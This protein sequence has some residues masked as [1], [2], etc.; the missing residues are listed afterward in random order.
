MRIGIVVNPDAGL[1]GKLGFK[2]SDGR[3]AEARAAG[4]EDRAGPR[5]QQCLTHL[6]SLTA[7]SL[8][9][10]QTSLTFVAWEGR[11]GS[12]WIPQVD[13]SVAVGTEWVGSTPDSTSAEDTSSLVNALLDAE[14]DALLYAGG[15]GTTRDIVKALENRGEAAQE[16]P[17]I[18]VPGGVK[19][20]SGCFATTPKAAAEVVLSFALGDLRTAITE[21]MDLDEVVYQ[22]GVWKVR[23]YGE[24]W[25][26]SSPRF[27]QGAKEQVERVSEDDSIEGLANHIGSLLEDED[28]LMVVWGSGGTL[29]RMGEHLNQSLTLLGIDI[30]HGGSLHNDLD[31]SELIR[32]LGEHVDEDGQQR[33]LLLLLS[34]M[35]GQGFLIGRGNLQLSPTVLRLVG[36]TN[37]LGVATPSKLI[38]LE[39][40]R[41]DTGDESLDDEFQ[42]KRFIKILQGFRTTRLIRVA[43]V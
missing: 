27:M 12:A 34:P 11:M 16:T 29:R 28:D 17:L 42:T 37:I 4:A 21:V 6:Q 38:G 2:G 33:P 30:Q 14:V 5:M 7:S 39:A 23:M 18:G 40:V 25:T 19:M 26:P 31:E 20:H 36:H 9:R 24:A 10:N 15:D 13:N 35:G 43:E 32:I 41:I 22:E 3:A 1:G 8:N